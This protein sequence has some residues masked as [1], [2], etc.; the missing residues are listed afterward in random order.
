MLSGVSS[1]AA[2]QRKVIAMPDG[3]TELIRQIR[4]YAP[5]CEQEARDQA[6]MLSFASAHP[7]CLLRDNL[8]AHF[9][10]S[11]WTVNPQHT[12]VLMVYHNLYD[13]WSW[14]GGHAD[15]ESDLCAV[16]MRELQE[17]T[18]VHHA[19]LISSEIFSLES[20]PVFG[21]IKR[22]MYVP[23]HLHFNLTYLAEADETETLTICE[24]EN[25]GVRW[26]TLK[27]ALH[28]PSEAWMVEHV[29]C[30]LVQ[31]CQL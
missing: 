26:F 24:A 18:G 25:S 22:G 7:D 19:R 16:A 13:S 27:D 30:K 28:A 2:G 1:T 5:L 4:R 15:G 9:S 3:M 12:Q 31:R 10:A 20:L 23:S 17:E 6:Q 8:T 14:V 21:H 11:L 29:Y